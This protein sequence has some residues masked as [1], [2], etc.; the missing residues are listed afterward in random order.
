MPDNGADEDNVT[1]FACDE[2][3]VEQTAGAVDKVVLCLRAYRKFSGLYDALY[4]S[5]SVDWQDRAFISHFTLAGVE[6]TTL[7]AFMDR[8]Q[9][10]V[11]R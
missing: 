4:V 3:F 6:P 11:R 5:G 8:F 9:R 1:N 2:M 10:V 7:T